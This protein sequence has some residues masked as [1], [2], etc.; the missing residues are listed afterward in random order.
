M[1]DR[2]AQRRGNLWLRVYRLT[3]LAWQIA[4]LLMWSGLAQAE[5]RF[6]SALLQ[7]G[8]TP[9]TEVDLA[10]FSETDRQPPGEYRVDVF[11]NGQRLDTRTLAFS[12]QPDE[13]GKERLQPCLQWAELKGFGVDMAAFPALRQT[14]GCINLPQAIPGA[15]AELLFEQQQLKLSIPQAALKR[16]ARGYVPPEQ[17]DSGIPALLSNYTLRG[18]ND[19]S[20]QGGTSSSYFVNLR[21]GANWGAWR[22]R[23]DSVWNRDGQ[24]EAHWRTLN[25]YV[26][27]DITQFNGLLTLGDATTPGNIFDS[28]SLRGVQLA[29]V[30]DM[31]PDSLRGYSPVVRGIARSNAEVVI[32]QNGVVIDQRYVPPGAFE[33]SDLYAVSGSGDLDVTIKESDGAEQ[34]VLVPF[35]SLPVLQREGRL[36]YGLAAG[37]YRAQDAGADEEQFMQSTLIYGLPLGTTLYGGVQ[38]ANRYHALALGVGQNLGR[39]GALSLDMTQS[40]ARRPGEAVQ[41]SD[42]QGKMWRL[43]YEKSFPLTGTQLSL[44]GYR[45]ASE[46]Y[47]TLQQ[48]MQDRDRADKAST[49]SRKELSLQQGLGSLP[50]S[51]FL[52]LTEDQSWHEPGKRQ[53][54]SLGYNGSIAG[55]S[56]GLNV[57]QNKRYQAAADRVVALNI[58]VPLN[59]WAHNT[60]GSYGVSNGRGGKTLQTLGVSGTALER[61]NLNWGM[62]G[63]YGNQG[64][65]ESGNLT[66]GYRG[67]RAQLGAG[68]SQDAQSRRLNYDVQGGVLLHAGGVTLSQPLNDTI[69]LVRAPGAGGVSVLNQVG[70]QTDSKGYAVVPY[71]SAYRQNQIVL[72]LTTLAD[73]V[74]LELTSQTVTPTRGAVVLADYQTKVGSR[75]MM[76]LIRVD[77]RP[78]PF[79]ATATLLGADDNGSI[80]GD[81]GQVF[82]AGM[83]ERGEVQVKWGKQ[84]EQQC[85][86]EYRLPSAASPDIPTIE[87]QCR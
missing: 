43:R 30:E 73:N 8:N 44:A 58:S 48:A 9:Q 57:S 50:G 60:W 1:N 42:R 80:V 16:Q 77:G 18:A 67:R 66:L 62:T 33:I 82:L 28:L 65:G 19:R 55:V 68:L 36:S 27:R 63:G 46:G 2:T 51:L 83:P 86:A 76:T 12:L 13:Q 34:H 3:P 64:E 72:D 31:Y 23:Q 84:A 69:A 25:S 24:G 22:V 35:A 59:L 4:G 41:G 17:W 7:I 56:Y 20:R 11:L 5:Y 14:N 39:A 45:H 6:S 71:L 29:S 81:G 54:V 52:N 49:R 32:R 38:W 26:Q 37:Q 53:S 10:L 78:V 79:G 61:D 74:E 21:N 15:R 40:W 87:A 47:R 70:V 85:R 75:L